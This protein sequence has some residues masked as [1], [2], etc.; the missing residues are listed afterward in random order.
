MVES[1]SLVNSQIFYRVT[2][3]VKEGA[4]SGGQE[5]NSSVQLA[6]ENENQ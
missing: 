6:V 4:E 3:E 1:S 5:E 2:G